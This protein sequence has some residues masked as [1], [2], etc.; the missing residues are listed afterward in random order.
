[1][2]KRSP[3]T[4]TA[5]TAVSSSTFPPIRAITDGGAPSRAAATM[6][7]ADSA[8]PTRSPPAGSSPKSESRPT[9]M[10]VPGIV[11]TSSSSRAS[12]STSAMR[13]LSSMFRP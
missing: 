7:Q 11:A 10:R 13:A 6:I 12:R 4:G 2:S 5:P 3:S 1:M 8:P 9:R